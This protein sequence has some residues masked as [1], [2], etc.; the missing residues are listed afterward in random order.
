MSWILTRSGLRF[1][2]LNPSAAVVTPQDIAHALSNICR[3]NGHT[4]QHYS[5]AQHSVLLSSIV[6]P[7][8]ALAGLLHD[9]TEAYVGDVVRPLK[10]LLPEYQVIEARIWQA[11]C[12]RFDLPSELPD[13]VK[14][15]DLYMLATER[16]DLMHVNSGAWPCLE[17]I[18]PMQIKIN[19]WTPAQAKTVFLDRLSELLLT[20]EAQR[21]DVQ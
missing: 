2:L 20:R 7:A 6:P 14:R 11:I 8:D 19:P 10:Q 17:G 21:G 1:D 3:F 12:V 4:F 13:S 16:R 9:A 5:V 18:E 15:A